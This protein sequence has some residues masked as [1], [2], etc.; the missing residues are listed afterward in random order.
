MAGDKPI[1]E[2]TVLDADGTRVS[3]ATVVIVSAE[4]PVP[5]LGY[6]TGEDGW[7]RLGLPLGRVCLAAHHGG[8][9]G[10]AKLIVGNDL[11][12]ERTVTL[13]LI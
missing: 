11:N 4:V 12:A 7:L 5:E 2:I 1:Y 10:H 8:K 3:E 6:L 9:T 13:V